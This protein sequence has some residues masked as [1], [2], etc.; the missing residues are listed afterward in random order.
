MST[1]ELRN[2]ALVMTHL[3]NAFYRKKFHFLLCVYL[4]SL[5]CIATLVGI[6]IY[7]VKHP[8]QPLYFVTDKIGRLIEDV[9]LEKANMPLQ[10]VSNWVVTAVESA[11]SYDFINYRAQLQNAQDYFTTLGWT[12]Y[13]DALQKSDNLLAL[14]RYKYVI[15]AKV[16]G[17]PIL[18]N[19]GLLGGALAW[20]FQLSLLVNYA[21]PPYNGSGFRNPETV[22][23]IVQRQKLL[24]SYQ[25]L[26][27]VQMIGVLGGS[28]AV[29]QNG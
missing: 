22:T 21:T 18:L 12:N 28:K 26:G 13:M 5:V 16:V 29:V 3:R 24:Q 7:L 14:E 27:I 25:G 10:S 2:D 11:R 4:L 19:E 8:T 20:K 23:V 6:I 15:T 17:R 1:E 9:P